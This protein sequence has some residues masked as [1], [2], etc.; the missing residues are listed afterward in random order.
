MEKFQDLQ[1]V[2]PSA[3]ETEAELKQQLSAF[4]NAS[5]YEEAKDAFLKRQDVIA[6]FRTMQVLA[7]IRAN[8]NTGDPFYRAEEDFFQR[9]CRGRQVPSGI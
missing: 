1:Y 3:E 7:S 6:E 8:M 4:R 2:R 5:S 9:S